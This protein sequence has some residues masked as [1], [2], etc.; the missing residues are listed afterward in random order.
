MPWYFGLMRAE[1]LERRD[2]KDESGEVM[3]YQLR[4]PG[5]GRFPEKYDGGGAFG[6]WST[7]ATTPDRKY[8]DRALWR[9]FVTYWDK[10]PPASDGL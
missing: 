6:F 1:F 5:A 9:R 2:F 7:L 10:L 3:E 4:W 8:G